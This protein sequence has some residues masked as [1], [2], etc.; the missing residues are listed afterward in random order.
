VSV[1]VDSFPSPDKVALIK[2]VLLK[3]SKGK[4]ADAISRELDIKKSTF[5]AMLEFIV[6]EG[7]LREID[8]ENN[9]VSCPMKC[10]TPMNIKL[11]MLTKKGKEYIKG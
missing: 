8:C 7:Y 4:T 9:C 2:E 11:Y 3:V 6:S 5:R 10:G 1:D